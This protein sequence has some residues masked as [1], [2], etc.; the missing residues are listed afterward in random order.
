MWS[1][2]N[3]GCQRF[4][5]LQLASK[6]TLGTHIQLA[7]RGNRK[8]RTAQGRA[9]LLFGHRDKYNCKGHR[10]ISGNWRPQR[11]GMEFMKSYFLCKKDEILNSFCLLTLFSYYFS[12]WE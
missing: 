11:K 8:Y 7:D 9:S 4:C 2:R 1:C 5:L 12:I 6:D 10:E 3:P